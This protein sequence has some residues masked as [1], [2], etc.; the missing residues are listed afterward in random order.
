MCFQKATEAPDGAFIWHGDDA[1]IEPGKHRDF[2]QHLFHCQVREI[3]PPLPHKNT[4]HVTNGKSRPASDLEQAL[5]LDALRLVESFADF[6]SYS[7]M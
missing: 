1:W 3:G 4:R 6:F 5:R 2:L 7:A